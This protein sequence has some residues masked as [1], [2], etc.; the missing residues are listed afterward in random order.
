MSLRMEPNSHLS[1]EPYDVDV[2]ALTGGIPIVF[3]LGFKDLVVFHARF[4]KDVLGGDGAMWRK[5]P[6]PVWY[7]NNLAVLFFFVH[8]GHDLADLGADRRVVSFPPVQERIV[9]CSGCVE[10]VWAPH[11]HDAKIVHNEC[12]GDALSMERGND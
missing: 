12:F 4:F 8:G 11:Y 9:A 5:P 2:M 3:S 1:L 6:E 7:V 10:V